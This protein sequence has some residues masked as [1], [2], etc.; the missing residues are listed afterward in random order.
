MTLLTLEN[1]PQMQA[2]VRALAKERAA[3]AKAR[4]LTVDVESDVHTIDGLVAALVT[5]AL[6]HPRAT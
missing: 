4:G 3:T 2:E 1:V 6:E 5:W